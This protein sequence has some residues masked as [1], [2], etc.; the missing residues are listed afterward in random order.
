MGIKRWRAWAGS[1]AVPLLLRA[2]A[3]TLALVAV[4]G[5]TEST[6]IKKSNNTANDEL[7]KQ[8]FGKTPQELKNRKVYRELSPKIIRSIPDEDLPQAIH[9]FIGLKIHQDWEN[10]HK[11]VPNLG[12]GFTAVYFLSLLDAEVN[13]GGFYQ[14]FYNCGRDSVV[15]AKEGADLMGLRALSSVVAEALRIEESERAKMEAVKAKGDL[16]EFFR[17]YEEISFE[18]ADEAFMALDLDLH[19]EQVRFIRTHS[20]MFEGRAE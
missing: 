17:S 8:Y 13:N 14:L 5:C 6:K 10:D 12:P 4:I 1:E 15:H 3:A 19:K 2:M 18:A 11:L 20:Q 16:E 7:F 9:D